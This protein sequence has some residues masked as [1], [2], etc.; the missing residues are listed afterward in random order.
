MVDFWR[1]LRHG[2]VRVPEAAEA[3]EAARHNLLL[4]RV[5]TLVLGVV[6]T[7]IA[8]F[9]GRLG[10]I[11]VIANT[12]VNGFCGPM[13]AIFLL[14]LLSKRARPLGV[15]VGALISLLLMWYYTYFAS[16]RISFQWPSTVGLVIA[17]ALGYGLSLLE[18][19]PDP[20]KLQWTLAEQRKLWRQEEAGD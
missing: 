12:L 19:A 4:A 15:C 3:G 1:R 14:G 10:S 17:L 20:A 9:V 5:L 11:I 7:I 6:V 18:R 16:V 8:C 2:E 13:F